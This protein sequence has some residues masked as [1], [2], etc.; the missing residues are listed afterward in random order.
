MKRALWG[1]AHGRRSK[2]MIKLIILF[3]GCAIVG[4]LAILGFIVL[5]AAFMSAKADGIKKDDQ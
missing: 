3:I 1:D 4:L 5:L 2:Q